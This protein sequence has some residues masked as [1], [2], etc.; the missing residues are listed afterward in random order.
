[1]HLS[2]G[3]VMIHICLQ[4]HSREE[5]GLITDSAVWPVEP[6]SC[7]TCIVEHNSLK[8]VQHTVSLKHSILVVLSHAQCCSFKPVDARSL[9][10]ANSSPISNPCN[11][12]I[13]CPFVLDMCAG[14][15]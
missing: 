10:L 13:L 7:A 5:G 12:Q 14:E 11:V 4:L 6:T 15:C 8:H 1:M 2:E 3:A 9:K